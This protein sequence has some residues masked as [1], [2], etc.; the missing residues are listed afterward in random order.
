MSLAGQTIRT[1]WYKAAHAVPVD[2]L[3]KL[4]ELLPYLLQIGVGAVHFMGCPVK[5]CSS[6]R[7][8]KKATLLTSLFLYQEMILPAA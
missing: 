3:P 7:S 4:I 5:H 8:K 6:T 2:R 1:P